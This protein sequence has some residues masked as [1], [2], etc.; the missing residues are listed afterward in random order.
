MAGLFAIISMGK[1]GV[2]YIIAI[3]LMCVIIKW[4][5]KPEVCH[6]LGYLINLLSPKACV[7][8]FNFPLSFVRVTVC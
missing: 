7:A 1:K 3:L 6:T 8:A 4:Q 2:C 5:A